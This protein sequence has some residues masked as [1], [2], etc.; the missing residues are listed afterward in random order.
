MSCSFTSFTLYKKRMHFQK[1]VSKCTKIVD[2][3][4][5][6]SISFALQVLIFN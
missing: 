5:T 4:V 1:F 3:Y 2:S 6:K